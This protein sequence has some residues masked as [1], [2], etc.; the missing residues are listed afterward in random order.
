MES[1]KLGLKS[2]QKKAPK[3]AN[4]TAFT[5]LEMSL[6]VLTISFILLFCLGRSYLI[7]TANIT[8][9]RKI[10]AS[11]P[12]YDIP[13]NVLWLDIA[14]SSAFAVYPKD[15]DFIS[16]WTDSSPYLDKN[17]TFSQTAIDNNNKPKFL[18]DT[19]DSLP[20]L[21]FDGNDVLNSATSITGFKMGQ[22]N[23]ITIFLVQ[24]YYSPLHSSEA[25]SWDSGS[26]NKVSVKASEINGLI[27]FEFGDTSDS[28]G[29]SSAA[30]GNNFPNKW[31]IITLK[32]STAGVGSIRVNGSPLSMA[33]SGMAN[34]FDVSGIDNLS[35]GQNLNGALR[36]IIIYKRDLNDMEITDIEKYL[37]NKWKIN[38]D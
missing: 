11:S 7:G 23:Q 30:S 22:P 14:Q 18:F 19:V 4:K 15:K 12:I 33:D 37:S 34:S 25:I 16:S 9:L 3:V 27:Y 8:N 32:R 17:V 20:S 6:V 24:K 5:L 38:I 21:Y 29:I 31:N 13:D 36:E 28:G 10:A 2:C 1:K 35:I 26:N